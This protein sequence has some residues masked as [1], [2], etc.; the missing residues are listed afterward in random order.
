M[1]CALSQVHDPVTDQ[2]IDVSSQAV[3]ELKLSDCIS[4]TYS[5]YSSLLEI[6]KVFQPEG[7]AVLGE[8]YSLFS[9]VV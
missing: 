7:K 4:Y 8:K 6:V 5:F 3:C 2:K 9:G 1:C